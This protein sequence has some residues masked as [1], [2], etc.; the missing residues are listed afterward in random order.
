MQ[1]STPPP[2]PEAS[3]RQV[4]LITVG[5]CLAV[6]FFAPL[7]GACLWPDRV[8]RPTGPRAQKE[9]QEPPGDG[10]A[11][12]PIF[13]QGDAFGLPPIVPGLG[14]PMPEGPFDDQLRPD[15]KGK[16]P[17][18]QVKIRGGCWKTLAEPPDKSDQGDGCGEDFYYQGRCYGY[19][20]DPTR[21]PRSTTKTPP[22][23][24]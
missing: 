13:T 9:W 15:P 7:L 21:I 6:L 12:T 20:K 4:A 17:K 22:T 23:P 16:C 5:S 2:P 14:R 8:L 24:Q 10:T 3:W 19:V 11:P 1:H 18:R